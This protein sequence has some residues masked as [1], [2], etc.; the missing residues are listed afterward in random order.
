MPFSP[1]N[2]VSKLWSKL[3]HDY[4]LTCS[5]PEKVKSSSPVIYLLIVQAQSRLAGHPSSTTHLP[6]KKSKSG[7][8]SSSSSSGSSLRQPIRNPLNVIIVPLSK[9]DKEQA[10]PLDGIETGHSDAGPRIQ[11]DARCCR[12]RTPPVPGRDQAVIPQPNYSGNQILQY[13]LIR[14]FTAALNL[15]LERGLELAAC[16]G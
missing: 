14:V 1:Y 13:M 5:S 10:T 2:P 9:H 16:R 3:L 11:E 6:R 8:S 15:D 12:R 7:S 4:D